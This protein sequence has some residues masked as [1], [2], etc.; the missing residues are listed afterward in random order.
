MCSITWKFRSSVNLHSNQ[1]CRQRGSGQEWN[2]VANWILKFSNTA[3]WSFAPMVLNEARAQKCQSYRL[4]NATNIIYRRHQ[5]K[6]VCFITVLGLNTQHTKF[7]LTVTHMQRWRVSGMRLHV[8]KSVWA[9]STNGTQWMEGRKR[10][11][12]TKTKQCTIWRRRRG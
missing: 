9:K 6:W 3:R 11:N 12:I 7:D 1:S 5:I 10:E 8:R 2:K 4:K